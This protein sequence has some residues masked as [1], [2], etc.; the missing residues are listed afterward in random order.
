MAPQSIVELF[1]DR[2]TSSPNKSA[3]RYKS[4]G[5]WVDISWSEYGSLVERAGK[6]LISLGFSPSDKMSLLSKNRPAWH[7]AD[8]ACLSVGGATAPVYTTNSPEQVA[9]IVEHSDSKVA[10][11]EDMEQLEKVL[12]MRS[13]LPK[14]EKVVVI[15]GYDETADPDFVM[16]WDALLAAGDGSRPGTFRPS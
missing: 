9:Y 8:M 11:V 15:S 3:L 10:V 2:T 12:K 1:W 6:G 13:E 4:G 7:V 16:T 14:L 5:A